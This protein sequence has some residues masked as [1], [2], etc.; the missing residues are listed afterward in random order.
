M[1]LLKPFLPPVER[2]NNDLRLA[3]MTLLWRR[4]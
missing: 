3:S 4:R 1:G 2:G